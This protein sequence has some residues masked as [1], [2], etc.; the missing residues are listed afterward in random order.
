MGIRD[1]EM[2]SV[3]VTLKGDYADR[4]AEALDLL[5]AAGLTV[6][7]YDDDNSVVEGDIRAEKSHD[8]KHVACVEY[9]RPVTTW[10]ADYPKGDPRD[11]ADS[12]DAAPES[13]DFHQWGQ[14]NRRLGKNYP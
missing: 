3:V 12:P 4:M 5:R 6:T 14:Y 11:S 9:V 13:R 7:N 8:L 10:V 2:S 1:V